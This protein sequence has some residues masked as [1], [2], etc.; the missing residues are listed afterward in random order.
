MSMCPSKPVE[1]S[2]LFLVNY[3]SPSQKVITTSSVVIVT[4]CE[5]SVRLGGG[6]RSINHGYSGRSA[7]CDATSRLWIS[8]LC[9]TKREIRTICPSHRTR[10]KNV[11]RFG[12]AVNFLAAIE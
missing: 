2:Q 5:F 1:T 4:V 3:D 9:V 7:L 8:S 10:G 6:S 12:A 11:K